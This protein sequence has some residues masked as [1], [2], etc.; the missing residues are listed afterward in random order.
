MATTLNQILE[1]PP[2]F[3]RPGRI[4]LLA[5]AVGLAIDSL[6][7]HS[8]PGIGLALGFS[9]AIGGLAATS[10]LLGKTRPPGLLAVTVGGL[11]VSAFIGIRSSPVLTALNIGAALVAL[12]VVAQ[13]SQGRGTTQSWTLMDYLLQPLRSVSDVLV[14]ALGFIREDIP[15]QDRSSNWG[16]VRA[17]SVGLI[18]GIP[19][20][21]VFGALFASADARF[22][23]ILNRL[24]SIPDLGD[25]I[26]RVIGTVI[27]TMIIVGIWSRARTPVEPI[28][29]QILPVRI[30]TA[31]G[32]TVLVSLVILFSLFVLTQVIGDQPRLVRNIDFARNA[33]EGFF[34]LVT[35]T[36][37]VMAVLLVFDWLIR[38]EDGVRSPVIC[39]PCRG[40]TIREE[41]EVGFGPSRSARKAGSVAVTS[42]MTSSNGCCT[43][44]PIGWGRGCGT[45]TGLGG[46]SQSGF[47]SAT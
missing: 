26:G 15:S 3:T 9:I 29:S 24:V 33:R 13:M 31:S 6:A 2:T 25:L 41:C 18:L 46:R 27:L 40:T 14:G 30:R 47:A 23:Q 36:A 7:F 35:V 4:A 22:E 12:T 21:L 37:L 19:L 10:S 45:R 1:T 43:S 34:E 39:T 11:A 44:C 42:T 28:K 38:K 8:P 16:R 17:I 5:L 20:L 32:V